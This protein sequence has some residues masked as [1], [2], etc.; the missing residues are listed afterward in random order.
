MP[1]NPYYY[2]NWSYQPT[3]T[4]YP[5]YQPVSTTP[6]QNPGY[7]P[8]YQPRTGNR[9]TTVHGIDGAKACRLG[10]N[11]A[12]LLLDD[13]EPYVYLLTTDGVGYPTLER[14][15]VT[16]E[17]IEEGKSVEIEKLNAE[18]RE[19]RATIER[20]NDAKPDIQQP[21]IQQGQPEQ[22]KPDGVGSQGG[23]DWGYQAPV[24]PDAG[25]SQV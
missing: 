16:P 25:Q 1:V 13:S 7:A 6:Y 14:Y 12:E 4:A 2:P 18:I 21:A 17:P 5:N 10:P 20:M 9:V 3:T 15:R 8:M 11:S 22:R 19:L 24:R 23:Y